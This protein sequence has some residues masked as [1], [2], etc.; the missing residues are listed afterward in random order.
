MKVYNNSKDYTFF[1]GQNSKENWSLLDTCE[2]GDIIF[3][4]SHYPSC[5]VL[6]RRTSETPDYLLIEEGARLCKANTKYKNIPKIRV[7]Y[8]PCT[9]IY[10]G[11]LEGEMIYR[12]FRKV[13]NVVI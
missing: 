9:N 7:D 2:E 6:L 3:H 8:T 4:L 11:E 13:N 1:I 5:Y 10:K 12:S